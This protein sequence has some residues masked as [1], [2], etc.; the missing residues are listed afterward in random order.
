MCGWEPVLSHILSLLRGV[1]QAGVRGTVVADLGVAADAARSTH[2]FELRVES[3]L[4]EDAFLDAREKGR[5][6]R[7][8]APDEAV[9]VLDRLPLMQSLLRRILAEPASSA[10]SDT[11]A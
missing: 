1:S 9:R 5:T 2:M 8:F 7:W 6:R 10:P 4:P 3:L 11:T